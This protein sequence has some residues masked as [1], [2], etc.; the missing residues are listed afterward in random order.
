MWQT[1][2]EK[3]K[4]TVENCIAIDTAALRKADMFLETITNRINRKWRADGLVVGDVFLT[5]EFTSD[6]S[7]PQLRIAG[8]CFGQPIRQTIRLVSKP[9][10]F[11]GKRWYMICPKTG[12]K[13]CKVILPPGGDGFASVNG[14]G[15]T[16]RSQRE[17]AMQR[18]YRAI[19]KMKQKIRSFPER[20]RS[21]TQ[22][23]IRQR[24]IERETYLARIEEHA[25]KMII[26]GK[27]L[28]M[29]KAA[30]WA[31]NQSEQLATPPLEICAKVGN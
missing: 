17:D 2:D 19:R 6:F 11:G 27:R 10:R 28:S 3:T 21:S 9:M 4:P 20:T 30:R 29:R 14:G 1:D 31:K 25:A 12:R 26:S 18:S 16:Y 8:T 5:T 22:E 24:L 7:Y 23:R 13:C 15:V